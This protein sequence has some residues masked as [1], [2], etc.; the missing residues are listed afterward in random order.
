MN[1]NDAM[2]GGCWVCR[3]SG[4]LHNHKKVF[5]TAQ[6]GQIKQQKLR[7]RPGSQDMDMY[8]NLKTNRKDYKDWEGDC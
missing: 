8:K 3:V 1:T 4:L 2:D 6:D 5:N 7:L